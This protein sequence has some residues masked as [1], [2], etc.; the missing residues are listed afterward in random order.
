MRRSGIV[1]VALLILAAIPMAAAEVVVFDVYD[2]TATVQGGKIHVERDIRVKNI[3]QNPIIPGELH[4]R[5]HELRGGEKRPIPVESLSARSAHGATLP[6]KITERRGETSL[7]V[8]LWNPLLPQFH[9]DFSIEYVLDFKPSGILFYEI[10]LPQEETTIPITNEQTTFLLRDRYHIT[11]APGGAI[12]SLSGNT[13]VTWDSDSSD[14]VLE[15]SV[16]PLP[17]TGVRA[18]NL[19]WLVI[20]AALIAFF[21]LTVRNQNR[22]RPAAAQTPPQYQQPQWQQ[23]PSQHQQQPPRGAPPQYRQ[24]PPGGR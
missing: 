12:S 16:I 24:Q 22:P 20:I 3:G 13:V 7:S 1:L 23:P 18:V 6:T 15:Y 2:T 5:L 10:R 4:F 19:F 14:R 8:E 11:Y 21:V 9:Y 17:R